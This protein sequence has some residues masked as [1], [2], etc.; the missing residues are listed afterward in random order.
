[1]FCIYQTFF[2][3]Y[4]HSKFKRAVSKSK[5][6]EELKK[7]NISDTKQKNIQWLTGRSELIEN[8]LLNKALLKSFD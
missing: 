8:Y 5:R 3:I 6:V 7:S 4:H 1:M 2:S